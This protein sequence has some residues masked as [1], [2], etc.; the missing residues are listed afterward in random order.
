MDK[1]RKT[2]VDGDSFCLLF[3][4]MAIVFGCKA[5]PDSVDSKSLKEQLTTLTNTESIK[6]FSE[7]KALENACIEVLS[8]KSDLANPDAVFA[9][10]AL[11]EKNTVAESMVDYIEDHPWK[12]SSAQSD[13]LE[14]CLV[15]LLEMKASALSG[16]KRLLRNQSEDIQKLTILSILKWQISSPELIVKSSDELSRLS[17][18]GNFDVLVESLS[19][20]SA[21]VPIPGKF[22]KSE[23]AFCAKYRITLKEN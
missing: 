5:K 23:I 9:G 19:R 13:V 20:S 15:A 21:V 1:Y 7:T 22:T 17:A 4:T 11:T 8:D 3:V 16:V 2:F 18:V 6:R 14:E 12:K 10:C